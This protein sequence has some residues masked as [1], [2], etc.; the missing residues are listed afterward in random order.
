MRASPRSRGTCEGQVRLLVVLIGAAGRIVSIVIRLGSFDSLGVLACGDIVELDVLVVFQ[1]VYRIDP[2]AGPF[3]DGA[4]RLVLLLGALLA[5]QA[6]GWGR[7]TEVRAAVAAPWSWRPA[8]AGAWTEASGSGWTRRTEP[9]A[10]PKPSGARTAEAAGATGTAAP[11]RPRPAEAAGTRRPRRAVLPGAC[12]ADRQI[13]S[14][15][16][17][18]VELPDDFF[19]N[20]TFGVLHEREAARTARLAIHRH[21]DV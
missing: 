15:E 10:T 4:S 6:L 5:P 21:D 14:L 9:A 11:A 20:P 18:G 2:A 19:G 12:F 13:A 8:G 3:L 1:I 7:R 17:L 16:R